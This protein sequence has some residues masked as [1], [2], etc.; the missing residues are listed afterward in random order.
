MN[1]KR[2]VGV[3][4]LILFM[5]L[6]LI[7]AIRAG[8]FIKMAENIPTQW[9]KKEVFDDKKNNCLEWSG[10]YKRSDC[11]SVDDEFG[12]CYFN[13]TNREGMSGTRNCIKWT[14]KDIDINI[15]GDVYDIEIDLDNCKQVRCGCHDWGCALACYKCD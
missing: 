2:E 1:E 8:F 12:M 3:G 15:T 4:T 7:A 10:G 5:I 14:N 13:G 11:M 9:E 6:I